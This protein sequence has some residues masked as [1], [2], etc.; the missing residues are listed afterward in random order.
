MKTDCIREIT[1]LEAALLK[2][3]AIAHF[4]GLVDMSAEEALRAIRHATPES[5][6]NQIA[7]KTSDDIKRLMLRSVKK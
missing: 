7:S 2:I 4:G 3:T 1:E 5:C 6:F